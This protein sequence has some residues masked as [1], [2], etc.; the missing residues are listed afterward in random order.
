VTVVAQSPE[1]GFLSWTEPGMS[2]T[3]GSPAWSLASSGMVTG[4]EYGVDPL[5]GSATGMTGVTVTVIVEVVVLPSESDTWYVTVAPVPENVSTGAR[6][7]TCVA[8]ST[9]YVPS[10]AIVTAD[11]YVESPGSSS[12]SEPGTS[13]AMPPGASF[14]SGATV[15]G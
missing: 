1:V 14:A 6:R 11:L 4:C 2:G 9:V 12:R 5:S 10:P 13:V 7:T 15:T 3:T 8:G